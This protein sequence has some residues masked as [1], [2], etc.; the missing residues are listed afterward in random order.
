MGETFIFEEGNEKSVQKITAVID[1]SYTASFITF[2]VL[3]PFNEKNFW[4][5]VTFLKLRDSEAIPSLLQKLD[6]DLEELPKL[7][8]DCKYY[9]QSLRE[10]YFDKSET[11]TSWPFLLKR[12]SL[13]ITIGTVAALAILLV[14][15]FNFINLYLVRLYKS[16]SS[17]AIQKLL[18]A[19]LGH[20]QKQILLESFVATLLGFG[21]SLVLVLAALPSFNKLF[22]ARLSISFLLDRSVLIFYFILI[23]ILTFIPAIYLGIKFRKRGF[24]NLL[25][26]NSGS[27]KA[28]FQQY[29]D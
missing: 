3:F 21:I 4:G 8:D 17:N 5:G 15:C 16:A 18:G 13:F 1:D 2:N 11:Q 12:D 9:L 7:T 22:G 19:S 25:N 14:A 24:N 27:L 29:H 26:A 23:V 6:S 28:G 10:F 20:V